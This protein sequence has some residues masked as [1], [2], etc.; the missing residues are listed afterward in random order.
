MTEPIRSMTGFGAA[1]HEVGDLSV[2]VEARSVNH[3]YL[4]VVARVPDDLPWVQEIVD[5]RVRERAGRGS[6]QLTVKVEHQTAAG[7]YELDEAL[8]KQLF[9]Q[10]QRV[11]KEVDSETPV[12]VR[13]LLQLEGV[14][15]P[16]TD[17]GDEHDVV[18]GAVKKTVDAALTKLQEMQV[19]EGAHLV[20]EMT[21]IL[22]AI[23]GCVGQLEAQ[24]ET[25][26]ASNRQR[27]LARLE[28]FLGESGVDVAAGDVLREVAILVEKSDIAEEV[29]RLRG[30]LDHYR[31]SISGGGRVGRKLDFL[32]QEMLREA[33]TSA[34]KV[35]QLQLSTV[36]VELK[37]ETDR[38]R[39][40]TQN[41]E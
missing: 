39:E 35:N 19:R 9:D 30:H 36:V 12:H 31:E 34:A 26:A 1:T 28:E 13:D 3:R 41:I 40:Q 7:R 4:K 20:E 16:T 23:G 37:S 22:E 18:E 8:L 17:L 29:G 27:Y 14:V 21:R 11:A 38:L 33:N 32:T 10:A 15:R 5:A 25:T 24:L 2:S 6:I